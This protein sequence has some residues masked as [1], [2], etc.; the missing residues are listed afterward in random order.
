MTDARSPLS[1]DLDAPG[2]PL[3]T[4]APL[5]PGERKVYR[6]APVLRMA[7]MLSV[8]LVVV[9]FGLWFLLEKEIRDMFTWPQIGTLLFFMV[10][11]IAF[12]MGVGLSSLTLTAAGVT[13]RNGLFRQTHP[14]EEVLDV[15]FGPGDSWAYLKLAPGKDRAE[16]ATRMVLGI[17][18]VEGPAAMARVREVRAYVRAHHQH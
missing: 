5:G 15:Q 10:F 18:R 17:Q 11:M 6:S 1:P 14:W 8:T 13:V 3:P 16:P 7:I 4:V 9:F 2:R 12:M